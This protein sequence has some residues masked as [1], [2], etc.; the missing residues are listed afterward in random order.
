MFSHK[1]YKAR[2]ILHPLIAGAALAG[3]ALPAAAHH[4][5]ASP[6]AGTAGPVV[7]RSPETLPAGRW[8]VSLQVELIDLD[9]I[10]DDRLEHF[11]EQGIEGVH[12]IE[13]ILATHLG[14][15]VGLRDNLMLSVSLPVV[16][17]T[18]I[19]EGHPEAPGV[20][21]VEKLGDSAGVGDLVVMG[22]WR[23]L[24]DPVHRRSAAL[25]AGVKIPTGAT[26]DRSDDGSERF[27]AEFQPGS[28]SWDPLIGASASIGAGPVTLAASV[29]YQIVTE[30]SRNTDLGDALNYDLAAAYRVVGGRHAH[31]DGTTESH[32][33]LDLVLELNGEWR[34]KEETSGVNDSHSGGNTLYISPG[35]RFTH[36]AGFTSWLSVGVPI[37]Q[38]LNGKQS[39][40][41][42]RVIAGI[43]QAF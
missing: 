17:R 12:G 24:N 36:P 41:D 43:A 8:S 6:G 3:F 28:G 40:A 4:P 39:D 2:T 18:D 29:L 25:I 34:A 21:E 42:V 9:D 32:R 1:T 23:F 10:E 22:T 13:T 26:K 31:H 37:A 16:R 27:E 15:A 11:A 30:G 14:A 20:G 35:L 33:A 5:S 7:T 19:D 38:H